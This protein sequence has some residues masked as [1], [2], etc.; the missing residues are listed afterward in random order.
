VQKAQGDVTG[1]WREVVGLRSAALE[2]RQGAGEEAS[3]MIRIAETAY[4]GGELGVLELLDA[5][6]SA[7]L[8]QIQALEL[9]VAARLTSIELDQ[10]TGG[11]V[12]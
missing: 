9:S 4:E 6:R 8:F 12:E 7:Y 2:A 3:R 1:L 5:Y 10:L 11:A